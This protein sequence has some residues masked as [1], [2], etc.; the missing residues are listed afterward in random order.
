MTA[1]Y[2]ISDLHIGGEGSLALCEFETELIEFLKSLS[3][4]AV[5]TEL[6]I[7]GDAF[8]FWEMTRTPPLEKLD[9]LIQEHPLLFQQFSQ[10]G[11]TVKITL[12]PGNHDYEL[13]CYPQF[14]SALKAYN[15]HLEVAEVITRPLPGGR[16][17]WIEHGHQHDEFNAIADFGNPYVTPLGYYIVSQVVD[18]L[19]E[20]A[21]F[22]KYN[23]LKDIES[24]YPNE[25]VPYWF[26][27]NYFY[28]EMTPWLRWALVPFLSIAIVSILVFISAALERAGI[29]PDGFFSLSWLTFLKNFGFT[30]KALDFMVNAVVF[31]DGLFIAAFV[32]T[33]IPLWLIFKDL[34]KTLRRYGFQA[35]KGLKRQKESLYLQAAQKAFSQSPEAL[36]FIYGHTHQPSLDKL[37]DRYVLNTG[38]WL[39]KLQRVPSALKF[40]PAIYYPSFQLNYFK[41]AASKMSGNNRPAV[42][43]VYECLPKQVVSELTLFEKMAIAG[44]K[45]HSLIDIPERTIHSL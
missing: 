44:Q 39:K 27:S 3:N 29:V 9:V 28:K 26:F 2:F 32:L 14:E 23:W 15:I 20:R 6:I 11:E 18:T 41:I 21:R 8:S 17:I 43:I 4:P 7:L 36:I 38:S 10:T 19:T 45:T 24:V 5:S 40:L 16:Q 42:E 33:L 1:Y 35:R 37:G 30:G 22:G 12:I 25:E 13:A 31:I 34:S